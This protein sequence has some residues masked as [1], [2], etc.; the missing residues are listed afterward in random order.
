MC[1]LFGVW[2][3]DGT[4]VS[5][6][7]VVRATNV[8]RHRGPDDEGYYFFNQYT[9]E[10]LAAAG[11]DTCPDLN[12]FPV[13]R[14]SGKAFHL[15]LGFRRLS[16]IDVSSAGHQPMAAADG[17]YWL[18]YNGE[19][20]NHAELREKLVDSGFHF[21]SQ[22]D[23]EVVLYSYARWGI[24]CVERFNGMWAFAI[25]DSIN[26][27]LVLS[28]DRFGIKP[29]YY[30]YLEG[31][32]L[33]FASEIKA[34]LVA[35]RHWPVLDTFQ[36]AAYL[37]TGRQPSEC[38]G[39]T[40]FGAIRAVPP[41]TTLVF[42][43][44]GVDRRK[45]WDIPSAVDIATSRNDVVDRYRSLLADAVCRHLQADVPVGSCL[46]G[47]LDSTAIVALV[48]Q[49]LHGHHRTD[50]TQSNSQITFSAVYDNDGP[51]N[52]K[53]LVE[54]FLAKFKT[55]CCFVYPTARWLERDLLELVWAQ[56][57]PFGS[58]SVFAQWCVMSVA[59]ANGVKVLLD[60]Q[61]ADEIL[62]GYDPFPSW[63]RC[64]LLQGEWLHVMRTLYYLKRRGYPIWTQ[65]RAAL[66]GAMSQRLRTCLGLPLA[67]RRG[68][69]LWSANRAGLN[70]DVQD[71][72]IKNRER[73]AYPTYESLHGVL[74][75]W[76]NSTLVELLR[77]EDR[78]SM[79]WSIEARVPYLDRNLVEFLFGVNH[80]MWIGNGWSKWIHRC[81]FKG[82][83]PD[84]IVWR[85]V[86]TGFEAPDQ[87]LLRE[88]RRS[89]E[90][91]LRTDPFQQYVDN[92]L[93]TKVIS[94]ILSRSAVRKKDLRLAWRWINLAVWLNVARERVA[95]GY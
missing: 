22:T 12:L 7:L 89:F 28:R 79:R 88:S 8:L 85:K 56:E 87:W 71:V 68:K 31:K 13:E 25:W 43:D 44:R 75:H 30:F 60:G 34:I 18:V 54:R 3:F 53:G 10:S 73:L 42:D 51:W 77:Y 36:V 72:L 95:S 55:E 40:F 66:L 86:K 14:C 92:A 83:L 4:S 91:Y 65:A 48:W 35:L 11:C 52:E 76:V 5:V 82:I 9:K 27:A 32:Q 21:T 33:I 46:S 58:L 69:L 78:N 23:T 49:T 26:Q 62:A 1:G 74:K 80:N 45:Y 84:E 93:V 2:N 16:I 41:A 63:L 39:E 90:P 20:Y 70:G 50:N 61:G 94:G 24:S 81:A 37:A 47:G 15:G 17:R 19:L 64:A 59:H 6:P 67:P 29:L 57:Q 38:N